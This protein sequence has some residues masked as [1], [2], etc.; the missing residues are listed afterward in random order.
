M[1][2]REQNG[3]AKNIGWNTIPRFMISSNLGISGPISS[4]IS[5]DVIE[6]WQPWHQSQLLYIQGLYYLYGVLLN[7]REHFRGSSMLSLPLGNGGGVYAC[8]LLRYLTLT[9]CTPLILDDAMGF[10]SRVCESG[11]AYQGY[12]SESASCFQ[13]ECRIPKVCYY[14]WS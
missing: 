10:F 3:Q 7:T 1:A 2:W 11:V 6:A 5:D 9:T 12:K 13:S 4:W 14:S 8:L